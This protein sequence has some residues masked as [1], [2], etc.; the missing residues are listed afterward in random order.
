MGGLANMELK[1]VVGFANMKRSSYCF[2]PLTGDILYIVG[3]V[4]VVYSPTEKVQKDSSFLIN[5]KGHAFTHIAM[6][7]GGAD[8][9]LAESTPSSNEI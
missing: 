4:V 6:A 8:V 5:P 2:Q 3:S 1:E 9:F 7:S